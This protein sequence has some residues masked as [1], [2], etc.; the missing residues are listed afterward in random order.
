MTFSKEQMAILKQA[1]DLIAHAVPDKKWA[2]AMTYLAQKEIERRTKSKRQIS[3]SPS[4]KSPSTPAAEFVTA[5]ISMNHSENSTFKCIQN[6]TY[7]RKPI[8]APVKRFVLNR[9]KCCQYKDKTTGKICGSTRFLQNDHRQ[10]VWAGGT[11]DIQNL[12]TLCAQHNQHK[13]RR[14]SFQR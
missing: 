1:Q 3:N 6:S 5:S 4:K 13:Y 11:N 7:K 8:P 9:D 10:S 12:Q 2:D 14:E